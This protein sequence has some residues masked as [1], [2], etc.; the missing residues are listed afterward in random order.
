MEKKETKINIETEI[1]N[2][3]TMGAAVVGV[4]SE[5]LV[6]KRVIRQIW[7]QHIVSPI[8]KRVVK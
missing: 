6:P 7:R 3:L 8:A 2:S 4:I 5:R 1:R